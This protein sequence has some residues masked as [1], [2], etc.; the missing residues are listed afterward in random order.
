MKHRNPV[1]SIFALVV[2]ALV[3]TSGGWAQEDEPAQAPSE[4]EETEE[5]FVEEITVTAT[6]REESLQDVPIAVTAITPLQMERSGMLDIR[7]L[8]T[9]ASS[10]NMNSSQ[11]EPQGTTLRVRGVGTTGNNIGLES[12]VGVFL[13][14]IYLSRPGIALGDQLDVES[15]E[16]LR[17]PQGTLFGRNV[18]AGALNL[19]TRRPSVTDSSGFLNLTVGNFNS[20]NAQAGIGGPLSERAGYRISAALRNQDGFVESVSGNESYN[21]DRGLVRGQMLWNF[22]DR[23]SL[24]IIGDYADADE[25]CCDAVVLL[26][27]PAAALGSFA[28]AGLPA[29]GGVDV[30]GS[31]AFEARRSNAGPFSNPFDQQGLSAELNYNLGDDAALTWLGSWR[32]F[33]ASSTQDDFVGISLYRVSPE[34][35]NGFESFDEIESWSQEF[36][37]A[38]DTQRVSWMIGGFASGEDILE[39]GG[40]GL[41]DDYTPFM[42]GILWN[43]A[44]APVLRA[45]PRLSNVPMAT[46][47][48]FGDVLA[49]DN[50]ALAFAGGVSAD[51]AHAKNVFRQKGDSWSIFTHNTFR[52]TDR[53]SFV[54]GLRYVDETKDGSFDQPSASNPACLRTLANAGALARGAA[55]TGLEQ[56]A[57]T[58]GNFSV[59]YACF[60]FAT[61]AN[62]GVAVLP[63]TFDDTFQDDELVHTSKAVFEFSDTVKGYASYTH[64]FKSGGFNLDSTAAVG[65]TDPRFDSEKIDALELGL[66]SEFANRRVRLNAT[67]FDYD[68]EDFQVLEFTGVQFVTFNVPKAQSR[69][70]EFEL[71]AVAGQHVTMNLGYTYADSEYPDDCAGGL[72]IASVKSLCGAK[73]TNAPENV[74]SFG[75]NWDDTVGDRFL[76]FA[77]VSG[78]WE[79][80]RRT[81]TQPNLA[82]DVQEANAKANVRIGLGSYS[83]RWTVEL[84]SNNVT[85]EQT[86]NVTFNTPLRAGSRSTFL[87]APRTAGATLRMTF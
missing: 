4:A 69:G 84:W 8:P 26:E 83:G 36:R 30:S 31:S 40:L 60:P 21:R 63:A 86:K 15:I 18:S 1:L 68:I 5:L 87:E 64:G 10:F 56:V 38:G 53:F 28:A 49:A 61:P 77:S 70:A 48:T 2:A 27:S 58:I 19:R 39:H 78:R 3:A 76:V 35:A 50:Q 55:G 51:G 54:A 25:N 85:D 44:F 66:K 29:D 74:V 9:L 79:D 71:S 16:V 24:R 80:D 23:G 17:G 72:D 46:G 43:Y 41:L 52:L 42:D 73:L 37:M 57:A 32:D 59:A 7:D 62:T 11:T 47:G 82:F 45:A 65:G 22:M 33:H 81:S 34:A 75:A 6:K 67:L 13:D 14:G 12:S 20:W